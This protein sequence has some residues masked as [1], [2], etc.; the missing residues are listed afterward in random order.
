MSYYIYMI[1]A[2]IYIFSMIPCVLT[3]SSRGG[4]NKGDRPVGPI[5]EMEG[6]EV[7]VASTSAALET[8]EVDL[9]VSGIEIERDRFLFFILFFYY[10][11]YL[12]FL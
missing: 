11:Y 1:R 10:Y 4:K 5:E 9:V 6:G 7:P 8:N 3:S 2:Y 12:F